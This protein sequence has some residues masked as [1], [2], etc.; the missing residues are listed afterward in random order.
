[1]ICF[2]KKVYKARKINVAVFLALK[3]VTE[4]SQC[5]PGKY[6]DSL[7]QTAVTG[8]CDAGFL[9]YGGASTSNPNDTVTGI[10]CPRGGYCPSGED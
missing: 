7:G 6:C 9:C 1:M 5:D 2:S 8:N 3:N 4:C 10:A